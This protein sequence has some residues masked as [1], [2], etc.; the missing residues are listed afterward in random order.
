LTPMLPGVFQF[1]VSLDN[2]KLIAPI[3]ASMSS[4]S[5]L[6]ITTE[7][8]W[9]FYRGHYSHSCSKKTWDIAHLLPVLI[10]LPASTYS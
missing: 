9:N 7:I 1:N 10:P 2:I 5:Y 8:G 4:E 6:S 3:S